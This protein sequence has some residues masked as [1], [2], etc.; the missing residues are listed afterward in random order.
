VETIVEITDDA[1]TIISEMKQTR[2]HALDYIATRSEEAADLA[3]ERLDAVQATAEEAKGD[4]EHIEADRQRL[5]KVLENAQAYEAEFI[6]YRGLVRDQQQEV[7]NM[8]E[9]RTEAVSAVDAIEAAQSAVLDQVRETLETERVDRLEKVEKSNDIAEHLLRMRIAALYYIYQGG[10]THFDTVNEHLDAMVALCTELEPRLDDP[11]N[12]RQAKT[13]RENAQLYVRNLP[14]LNEVSDDAAREPIMAELRDYAAKVISSTEALQADQAAKLADTET[15]AKQE[16]DERT[17]KLTMAR[18]AVTGMSVVRGDVLMFMYFT[19]EQDETTAKE[20]LAGVIKTIQ[21]LKGTFNNTANLAAADSALEKLASYQTAFQ[22]YVQITYQRQESQG[23]MG[24]DGAELAEAAQKAVDAQNA[25]L[26][27][28]IAQA[29]MVVA[30]CAIVAVI[31]GIV[32]AMVITSGILKPINRMVEGLTRVSDGDLTVEVE[33]EVEDEI[34]QMA[35]SLNETVR[36]LHMIM[37]EIREAS[38]QT[39][40]S[41][42]ELSAAA[43][44]ISS[45]A[46][47]QASSVEEISAS[48]QELTNSITDV[49]NNA[50]EANEVSTRTTT[51]AE[52]GNGTVKQSIEGMTLINESSTQISKIIGV[53]SQIANQTNLLA[54]NAA[55]EAASAGEHGMGFAVVADEVRKLA[56]RSSQAAEEITQLIEES[57]KRVT[58]GSRLSEEVGNSLTD[59]LGGIEQTAQGMAQISSG[60]AEQ[61][62]T[63]NQVARAIDGISAITEENSSSAEEMAASAEELSAQA[64]RLQG[65]VERFRLKSSISG[66]GGQDVARAPRPQQAAPHAAPQVVG[67]KDTL[68]GEKNL[69]GVSDDD[70]GGALYHE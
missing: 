54:L 32:L 49:A 60:T 19:R 9:H 26:S 10:Q 8:I 65:L 17:R 14:R 67:P 20:N 52:E 3:L 31:L 37:S 69:I 18:E 11:L 57:T 12:V 63:A 70:E 50:K 16:I 59:I 38:D 7:D 61:A 27:Q 22:N 15:K 41:G 64:Q 5:E 33:V 6:R 62:E 30:I 40:S 42:E 43:Q 51:V 53:I 58:E 34:G 68:A 66:F 23:M 36:N 13:I 4:L 25:K 55:I 2:I 45:G 21:S 28:Q 24:S 35:D 48:I 46:Q 29:N 44:N 1:H 47:N 56:E 39:A